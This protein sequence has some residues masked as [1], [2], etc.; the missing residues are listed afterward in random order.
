MQKCL[1]HREMQVKQ[2][3]KILTKKTKKMLDKYGVLGYND[4]RR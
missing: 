1:K 2:G 4:T 3:G